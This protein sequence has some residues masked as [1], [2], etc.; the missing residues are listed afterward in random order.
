M[1]KKFFYGVAI[2][3]L[4]LTL[5]CD[6]NTRPED[7]YVL[8]RNLTNGNAILT[9]SGADT[10]TLEAH[11]EHK[12][13]YPVNSKADNTDS[14]SFS[15]LGDYLMPNIRVVHLTKGEAAVTELVA[16]CCRLRIANQSNA[17]VDAVVTLNGEQLNTLQVPANES[18]YLK[19]AQFAAED[20]VSVNYEGRYVFAGSEKLP[21]VLDATVTCSVLPDAGSLEVFNSSSGTIYGVYFRPTGSTDMGSNMINM[22]LWLG[23]Y[24]IIKM[25]PQSGTVIVNIGSTYYQEFFNSVIQVNQTLS[26]V[27]NN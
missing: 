7:D 13:Y 5:S 12:W 21:L 6:K 23:D 3:L 2:L 22:P 27:V 24:R 11:S 9:F 20:S 16:D 1:C 10:V 26:I 18:A 25:L 19:L 14:L 17:V 4:L 8:I 15:F